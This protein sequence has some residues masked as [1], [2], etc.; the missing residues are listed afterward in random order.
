MIVTISTMAYSQSFTFVFL[1]KKADVAQLPKEESEKLMQGHM[2]NI[3]RLAKE[4][5]LI[6]AGPFEEGGGIFIF[7][8]NSIEETKSWLET[9]PGV[10]AKRW[11]VE[12]LPY[13]PRYG[14]VCSVEAPYTM[15]MYQFVRY[16][17]NLKKYTVQEIPATLKKHDDY[18]KEL[19]KDGNVITEGIFGEQEG[20]ILILNKDFPK[21]KLERDPLVSEGFLEMQFKQLY[22]ARGAFCE[23]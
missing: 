2:A 18:L 4:G 1:H 5:K 6:A 10:Q 16:A 13:K 9:D 21:E 8:S 20:G 23:K 14:S 15:V 17:V 11:N 3:E 12:V 19:I 7:K 22:I